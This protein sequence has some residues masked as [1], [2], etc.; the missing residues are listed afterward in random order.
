MIVLCVLTSFCVIFCV[1]ILYLHGRQIFSS[2]WTILGSPFDLI[3]VSLIHLVTICKKHN[4][5]FCGK[6]YYIYAS[7]CIRNCAI[8]NG[9]SVLGCFLNLWQ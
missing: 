1:Y 3:E 5:Y 8:N 4:R 6:A 7:V 9:S 2:H